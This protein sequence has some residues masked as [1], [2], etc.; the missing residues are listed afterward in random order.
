MLVRIC[1]IQDIEE[2]TG[3]HRQT[4]FRWLNHQAGSLSVLPVRGHYSW[5]QID[6]VWTFVKESKRRKRWLSYVYAPETNEVLTWS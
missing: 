1:G 4:V 2:V 5:V 6:Q 3:V